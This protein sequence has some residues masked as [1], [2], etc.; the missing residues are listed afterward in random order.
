[1]SFDL[2][3]SKKKHCIM[4]TAT[5]NY[6]FRFLLNRKYD[7][8]YSSLLGKCRFCQCEFINGCQGDTGIT[9]LLY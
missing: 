4:F 2:E 3:C 6:V 9:C 5:L 7:T 8:T 1:M